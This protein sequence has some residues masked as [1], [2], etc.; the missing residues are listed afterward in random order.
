MIGFA[1]GTSR[2]SRTFFGF[3]KFIGFNIFYRWNIQYVLFFTAVVETVLGEF[4]TL[5]RSRWTK[6]SFRCSISGYTM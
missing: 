2:F 3:I 4:R 5:K 1:F 6:N